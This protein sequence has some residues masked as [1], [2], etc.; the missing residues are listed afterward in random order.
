MN[1]RTA[2]AALAAAA[3]LDQLSPDAFGRCEIVVNEALEI[4]LEGPPEATSLRLYAHLAELPDAGD[5]TPGLLEANL[6]GR[7]TGGAFFALD[8]RSNEIVLVS[9]ISTAASSDGEIA[10][11]VEA[12]AK[13]ALFWSENVHLLRAAARAEP[14]IDASIAETEVILRL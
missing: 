1:N 12:F 6:S 4:V 10:D 14:E 3:G 11:R 8:T 9:E 5:V 13:T 2:I 7:E